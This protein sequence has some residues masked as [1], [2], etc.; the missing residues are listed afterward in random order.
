MKKIIATPAPKMNKPHRY[1][2]VLCYTLLVVMVT[3]FG[4]F[5][6]DEITDE[7]ELYNVG[8]G[9]GG[10]LLAV[11]VAGAGVF[12]LPYL[13]RMKVSPLMRIVSFAASL[14]APFGWLLAAWWM[15]LNL[16]T[17]E[18]FV[19]MMVAH[20]SILLAVTSAWITGVPVKPLKKHR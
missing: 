17:T 16:N 19:A 18:A 20:L 10:V 1:I 4:L 11:L 14:L 13:L 8:G 15:E 12:S 5:K 6:F 9:T 7:I 2:I 3:T